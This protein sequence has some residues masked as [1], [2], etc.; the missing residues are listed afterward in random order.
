[1]L[2]PLE[3][4]GRQKQ[5]NKVSIPLLRHRLTIEISD[6]TQIREIAFFQDSRRSR[7]RHCMC[8]GSCFNRYLAITEHDR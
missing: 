2:A 3:I 1:M 8:S 5:M 6:T 7:W 4:D